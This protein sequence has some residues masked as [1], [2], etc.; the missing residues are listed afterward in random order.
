MSYLLTIIAQWQN[1]DNHLNV[2]FILFFVYFETFFIV[3]TYSF[4]SF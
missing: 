3:E 2:L 1:Y 4:E